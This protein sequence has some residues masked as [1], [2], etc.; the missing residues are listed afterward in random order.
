MAS[1][2]VI[3]HSDHYANQSSRSALEFANAAIANQHQVAA[4]FFYQQGVLHASNSADVPSDELDTRQGFIKLKEQHNVE[5]LVC[6]TAAEK[7][8]TTSDHHPDFTIAGLAEMAG[9]SGEVDRIVQ[10]K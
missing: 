6:V 5:L 4:V 1:F 8:G 9:I 2:L 7:R 3:V 10:F